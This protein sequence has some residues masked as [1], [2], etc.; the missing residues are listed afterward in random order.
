MT[1]EDIDFAKRIQRIASLLAFDQDVSG[2]DPLEVVAA[3]IYLKD[4]K[5]DLAPT[6][7]QP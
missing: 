3:R 1:H 7:D 4:N 5:E 2:F 6:S